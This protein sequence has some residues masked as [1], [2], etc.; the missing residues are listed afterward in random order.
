MFVDSQII[1]N[2][3]QQQQI[4][5]TAMASI[6]NV[7]KAI[8]LQNILYAHHTE[9]SATATG[10]RSTPKELENLRLANYNTCK[11]HGSLERAIDASKESGKPIF[12]LFVAAADSSD[13]MASSEVAT[14]FSDP[15]MVCVIEECFVPAAFNTADR[16]DPTYGNAI[17]KFGPHPSVNTNLFLRILSAD[18]T[19]VIAGID[20][21]LDGV[22]V[23][24]AMTE[25]LKELGR[26]IP[27]FLNEKR[28]ERVEI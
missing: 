9:E 11:Q 3:K 22:T 13:Y 5:D 25:A 28:R 19:R 18:G 1:R 16:D 2:S 8:S 10:C 20:V 7:F 14:I 15:L 24:R 17:A 21:A 12:A 4:T 27:N 23:K 26:H 6:T